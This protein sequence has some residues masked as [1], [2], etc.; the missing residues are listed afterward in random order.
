[1]IKL[2]RTYEDFNGVTRTED[3]WF[4]LTKAELMEFQ[5]SVNGGMNTLLEGMIQAK[6]QATLIKYAKQLVIMSYGEK[7]LDGREFYK[8]DE[9]RNKFI[10]TPA[11]SDIFYDVATNDEYAA[12]FVN[13]IVP[14]EIR[15]E[16][17]KEIEEQKKQ[18]FE[19]VDN[20]QS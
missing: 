9:I 14:K 7:S 16:V 2:T 8:S 18:Q 5:T 15:E 20:K 3:F 11:F 1:M 19:V 13:G 4:N 12:M 6:D 10:A 17:A